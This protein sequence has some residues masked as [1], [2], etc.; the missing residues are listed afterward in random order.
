MATFVD[1][2]NKRSWEIPDNEEI[3]GI[4][5]ENQWGGTY[6]WK[7]GSK[8]FGVGEGRDLDRQGIDKS[9]FGKRD[10]ESLAVLE[11]Q[12]LLKVGGGDEAQAEAR[13]RGFI[14]VEDLLK[15]YS[16]PT[17][18]SE[19]ITKTQ[20]PVNPQGVVITSTTEGVIVESPPIEEILANARADKIK[21]TS[22]KT[23]LEQRLKTEIDFV[24]SGQRMDAKEALKI[25]GRYPYEKLA[26]Y[27]HMRKA[28]VLIWEKFIAKYPDRYVKVDYDYNLGI[29][30][31]G[32]ADD[33]S[34]VAKGFIK[35]KKLK[36]DVIAYDKEGKIDVI[37]VKPE[38]KTSAFGQIIAYS[39]LF[40]QDWPNLY[41]TPKIIT[42]RFHDDIK[43]LSDRLG[44]E[45]VVI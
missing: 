1:V 14:D 4:Q 18:P 37:E 25:I 17:G 43:N 45:I 42:N 28:D 31:A 13:K 11:N 33:P 44:I 20:S 15:K 8:I 5:T 2:I 27:P 40:N 41:I 35:L 7:I 36:A 26:K 6:Y 29:G 38:A 12:G 24:K 3:F 23:D 22:E 21:Q 32:L 34:S 10:A 39:I 30:A 16:A 9:M 19:T